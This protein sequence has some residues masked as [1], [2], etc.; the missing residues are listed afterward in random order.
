MNCIV[1]D[2]EPQARKLL[3]TYLSDIPG[4]T[5]VKICRNAMEAYEALQTGQVDLMFLDIRMPVISGIEFL[6][7]LKSPPLVIFT[8]AYDQYAIS[9]YE[10]DVVDYLLKPVA[11]PR[12]LLAVEKAKERC[13]GT[14]KSERPLSGYVFVKQ[15]NR[16]VKVVLNEIIY[17]ESMQNYV[18]LWMK[19]REL[20]VSS[21]TKAFEE[22]LPAKEFIRIHRSYIVS[23]GAITAIRAH[24]VELGEIV[25][26][27]GS[28][29][30]DQLIS[31]LGQ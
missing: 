28:S 4:L 11:L 29:Y 7:S 27:V 26:P 20:I 14:G 10:L 16:L 5:L 8:T 12:L 24:H 13:A 21:T 2:D 17:I 3:Q 30:R 9:G 19:D 22:Q 18:K 31:L 25:L 1:V 6:R 15:E 23:L